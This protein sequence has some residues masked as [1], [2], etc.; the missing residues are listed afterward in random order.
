MIDQKNSKANAANTEEESRE[1]QYMV[2]MFSMFID[3]FNKGE[4]E[5]PRRYGQD[6]IKQYGCTDQS[7]FYYMF[8]GFVGAIDLLNE[9]LDN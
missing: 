1:G 7:P 8:A 6:L 9:L 3:A 2:M 5:D 4:Y